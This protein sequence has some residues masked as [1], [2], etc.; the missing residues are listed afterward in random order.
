MDSELETMIA[1]EEGCDDERK[2][3]FEKLM[4]LKYKA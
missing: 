1:R 3:S 4:T 2:K